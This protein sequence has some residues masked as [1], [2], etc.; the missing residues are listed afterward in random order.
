MDGE[1]P[2]AL[3]ILLL[4]VKAVVYIVKH[5]KLIILVVVLVIGF[6]VY[7]NF[8]SKSDSKTQSAE[9]PSYQKILPNKVNAPRVVQTLS[10]YYPYST[11]QE[12]PNYLT[13]TDYYVYDKNSWRHE[14][15]PLPIAKNRIVQVF[16]R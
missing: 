13:L 12:D 5:P 1:L 7:R 6:S 9:I 3:K 8:A 2:L 14:T 10:R 15:K 11:F 4:P 16:S